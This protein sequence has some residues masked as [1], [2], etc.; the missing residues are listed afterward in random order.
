MD[1]LQ[2]RLQDCLPVAEA[3]CRSLCDE[4]ARLG[5][6]PAAVSGAD[7]LTAEFRLQTD[8]AS[9][10]QGLLGEWFDRHRYRVGMLLFHADGS[11]FAE[12]DIVRPH[13]G[14]PRLFVEA[15]EAWGRAQDIRCDARTMPMPDELAA[16]DA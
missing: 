1:A 3:L 2:Q 14:N 8:P 12:Y 16:T 6:D 9:G 4:A 11:F 10:G 15:V 5:F 13:P 7:A